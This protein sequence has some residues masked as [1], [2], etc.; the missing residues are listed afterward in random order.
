MPNHPEETSR[1]T[2]LW[3]GED[4][5]VRIIHKPD[6]EVTLESAKETMEAYLKI[7]QGKKRPLFV[8]T[9]MMKSLAR[10]ARQYYAGEEAAKVASAVALMVDTPVSKVLGNFYIGLSK[11]HLPSRLFSSD[12]EALEW[13]KGY[14]E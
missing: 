3:L 14:L 7:Y 1:G 8:D 12:S 13:L 11:P 4:G 10:E 2:K 6:A 5:I 9:K